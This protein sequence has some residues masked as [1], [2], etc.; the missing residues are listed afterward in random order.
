[1]P[2]QVTERLWRPELLVWS[3]LQHSM[4]RVLQ[5]DLPNASDSSA[6]VG[7]GQFRSLPAR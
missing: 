2:E 1:M 4:T 5:L 6:D 7:S 3:L